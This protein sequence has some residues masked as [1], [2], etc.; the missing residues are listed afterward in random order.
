MNLDEH[1]GE[2]L[3]T[4]DFTGTGGS[5][6][7][8]AILPSSTDPKELCAKISREIR[9]VLDRNLGV[10]WQT[11]LPV[12]VIGVEPHGATGIILTAAER[13]AKADRQLKELRGMLA[14]TDEEK[15]EAERRID[16]HPSN[17]VL[18]WW[19]VS[20]IRNQCFVRASSCREA[21]EKSKEEVGSW[22]QPKADWIGVEL[23]DVFS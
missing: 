12:D 23:P 8:K 1:V 22:E 18:G 20:G 11:T 21:L 14:P 16:Q 15:A 9:E 5:P 2:L 19:R 6:A 4:L 10:M 7:I 17:G 3:L 13:S